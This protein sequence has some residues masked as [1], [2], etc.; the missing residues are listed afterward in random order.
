MTTRFAFDIE[1]PD[2]AARLEADLRD[3]PKIVTRHKKPQQDSRVQDNVGQKF[4]LAAITV[5][6]EIPGK[7]VAVIDATAGPT[8][9]RKA[10]AK[11]EIG[12]GVVKAAADFAESCAIPDGWNRADVIKL[13][14]D[15]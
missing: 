4:D 6:H 3:R 10:T 15:G 9:A 5:T 2:Q 12:S 1:D 7:P 14:N 13:V 11:R 8:P